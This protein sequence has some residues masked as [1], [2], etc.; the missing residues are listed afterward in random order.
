MFAEDVLLSRKMKTI[1]F[2]VTYPTL[3][4]CER[5][6]T[7]LYVLFLYQECQEQLQLQINELK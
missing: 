3:F 1:S 4:L 5:D 2:L 7:V 6:C